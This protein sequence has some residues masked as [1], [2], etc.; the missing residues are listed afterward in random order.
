M[1]QRGQNSEPPGVKETGGEG[2]AQG[3]LPLEGLATV[4]LWRPTHS[5]KNRPKEKTS[6]TTRLT[7]E[8][9]GGAATP[10]SS[11][12]GGVGDGFHENLRRGCA[13]GKKKKKG[14]SS[15]NKQQL[16][17]KIKI[18]TVGEEISPNAERGTLYRRAHPTQNQ[19][20]ID[21]TV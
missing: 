2:K 12:G 14:V 6:N 17:K 4:A 20:P 21:E 10:R 1:G 19:Q 11:W 5:Q 15:E 8:K 16:G 18:S 9:K 7:G 13:D 3:L